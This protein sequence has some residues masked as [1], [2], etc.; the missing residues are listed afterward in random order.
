MVE[1]GYITD[2]EPITTTTIA[3][4]LLLMTTYKYPNHN[5][6]IDGM[7]AAAICIDNI[8][9]E[10]A[11]KI[12]TEE[13]TA[14]ITEVANQITQN[15]TEVIDNA[16]QKLQQEDEKRKKE[17][18][19]A[20]RQRQEID[21]TREEVLEK[22]KEA[23]QPPQ[24]PTQTSEE[25]KSYADT[26]TAIIESTKR[27]TAAAT[28]KTESDIRREQ[29]INAREAKR[30][31]QIL[32]DGLA[33]ILGRNATPEEV[34][35]KVNEAWKAI[36]DVVVAEDDEYDSYD[37]P[38]GIKFV[39]ARL[40]SN[41]GVILE[42]NTF[43]G[44]HFLKHP[45]VRRHFQKTLGKDVSIKDRQYSILVEFLPITLQQRLADMAT[46]IEEDNFYTKGDIHQIR[47]M[48]NPENSWRKDQQYA[49]AVLN[50][51]DRNRAN[52]I[53]EHGIVIA[54]KRYKARKLEDD[55]KRCYK[56]QLIE[57]G[58]RA[59]DCPNEEVC[60]NCCSKNHITAKCNRE[61]KDHACA[62]CSA[63]KIAHQHASWSRQCPTF[64]KQRTRLRERFPEN[65]YR[66]YP[67]EGNPNTWI[68]KQDSLDDE[69]NTE[70][71]NG[72]YN[73]NRLNETDN[74]KEMERRQDSGQTTRP[75]RLQG[76]YY[77]PTPEQPYIRRTR[78]Q[79][80]LP[81]SQT[82]TSKPTQ[83]ATMRKSV[84][85]AR[86]TRGRSTIR[87]TDWAREPSRT[88]PTRQATLSA[89]ANIDDRT[90]D[91]RRIAN[92]QNGKK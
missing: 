86:S 57:P 5:T 40:L 78:T 29:D 50:T 84:S 4:A 45:A 35:T 38:E 14:R 81:P 7:R 91:P 67:I 65:H 41:G 17:I 59:A 3:A 70:R 44:T 56:C 34:L 64:L 76:D 25:K 73:C 27:N 23:A 10:E 32:I 8:Q 75:T 77:R 61:R 80:P 9:H 89:W 48:R 74:R 37:K 83:T 55:P 53:I 90:R 39:T 60:A 19:E 6:W 12:I 85:R 88:S 16:N 69:M 49:H 58:H 68:R 46:I 33:N 13:A 87:R 43:Y 79:S 63:T 20:D 82:T 22:L 21:K 71:W 51:R 54:G 28:G 18:A 66:F 92:S 31:K 2:G 15:M 47:W 62:S 1:S 52:D 72:N 36:P 24:G 42:I 11:I 30:G 26:L